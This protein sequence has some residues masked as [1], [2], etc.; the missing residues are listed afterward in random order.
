ML[1]KSF[2]DSIYIKLIYIPILVAILLALMIKGIDENIRDKVSE[3]AKKET[4]FFLREKIM[5]LIDT[6][7]V[8][9]GYITEGVYDTLN[10]IKR[11]TKPVHD[12]YYFSVSV[13]SL[14]VL[15]PD[16]NL[17]KLNYYYINPID[18]L[19]Y[20]AE[21]KLNPK[22]RHIKVNHQNVSQYKILRKALKFLEK[23]S[24]PI[25]NYTE[26]I[27]DTLYAPIISYITKSVDQ[28]YL[29][30]ASYKKNKKE[31]QTYPVMRALIRSPIIKD[32]DLDWLIYIALFLSVVFF[33]F[34]RNVDKKNKELLR[35]NKELEDSKKELNIQKMESEQYLAALDKAPCGIVIA[36]VN[37]IIK[38]CNQTFIEWNGGEDVVGRKIQDVTHVLDFMSLWNSLKR[39]VAN[40]DNTPIKYFS[41][42]KE[43][44]THTSISYDIDT[45]SVICIEADV[46]SLANNYDNIRHNVKNYLD[47]IHDVLNAAFLN[48]KQKISQAKL[49]GVINSALVTLSRAKLL[50]ENLG[51]ELSDNSKSE[52]GFDIC[53]LVNELI[54]FYFKDTVFVL[55]VNISNELYHIQIDA[56]QDAIRLVLQNLILNSIAACEESSN[57]DNKII[58]R[59]AE[60]YESH[61]LI[62]ILDNGKPLADYD[63]FNKMVDKSQGMGLKIIKRTIEQQGGECIGFV[64]PIES[65]FKSFQFKLMK[66]L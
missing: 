7:I 19:A 44:S 3:D 39:K 50:L 46:T 47:K 12:S 33:L 37:G 45:N 4:V 54:T 53:W 66:K 5:P 28:K 35:V 24:M 31:K 27:N 60:E 64:Q 18:S 30:Q 25:F 21:M 65:G 26:I 43:K 59:V 41:S 9:Y 11:K 1:Q 38:K 10:E 14:V 62:E 6:S 32:K 52:N 29:V 8:K 49:F 36:D 2:L 17:L 58:I 61:C 16:S 40:K 34:F 57:R 42:L 15:Q 13:D 63:V 20:D 22:Y 55:N 56:S 51:S 48:G 23:D